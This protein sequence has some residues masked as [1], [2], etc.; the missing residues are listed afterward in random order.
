LGE[1]KRGVKG[2]KEMGSKEMGSKVS[3]ELLQLLKNLQT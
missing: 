2:V 1:L 3:S